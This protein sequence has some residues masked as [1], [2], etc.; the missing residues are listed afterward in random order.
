M[1]L[2]SIAAS[3][4][5]ALG[6]RFSLVNVVPP[7]ILAAFIWGLVQAGVYSGEPD[8]GNAFPDL[9]DLTTGGAVLFAFAVLLLGVVLA[10]FQVA[11]VRV[12]EGYWGS[13]NLAMRLTTVGVE[14]QRRRLTAANHTMRTVGADLQKFRLDVAQ[15]ASLPVRFDQERRRARLNASAQRANK[16][17]RQMPRTDRLLPTALGNNLRASEDS[18]GQRYGLNTNVVYPRLRNFLSPRLDTALSG[19][20]TQLDTS[21]ALCVSFTLA[22]LASTPLL[23]H[24]WWALI[25]AGCV[26][27]AVLA[28][29]GA[30]TAAT[31]HGDLLATAFDLHRFDLVAG[32]HFGLPN[33]PE[34]EVPF[35]E[36]LSKFLGL[37]RV[38]YESQRLP[39]HYVHPS[40]GTPDAAF[41]SRGLPGADD[42]DDA[43]AS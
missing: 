15:N 7:A 1:S 6:D 10:P 28:Y 4:G 30:Q 27:L 26:L 34:R 5:K 12:L 33:T 3:G 32:L 40:T 16:I 11:F 17:A 41:D 31:Y 14:L 8:L 29:R 21:A 35:N 38:D 39:F 13:A 43:A 20:L 24:Q 19:L 37:R 18:A 22:A 42:G 9:K 36:E 25:P 23:A 2:T